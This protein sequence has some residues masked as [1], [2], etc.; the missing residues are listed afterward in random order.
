MVGFVL[1]CTEE[2]LPITD[3][4]LA[5]SF[6][7]MQQSIAS[8]QVANY[9]YVYMVSLLSQHTPAFCLACVGTDNRCTYNLVVQR[10]NQNVL[11]EAL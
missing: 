3:S 8:T 9:A 11:N 10:W 2:G 4:L 1:P 6:N 7:Q 5:V